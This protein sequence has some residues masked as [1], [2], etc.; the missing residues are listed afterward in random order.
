MTALAALLLALAQT[1]EIVLPPPTGPDPIGTSVRHLVD[2]ARKDERFAAGR[3]I[4]LQ[5]WYPAREST[6]KLAP[7]LMEDGLAHALEEQGYYEV[8]PARL[9]AWG[10]LVTHAHLDAPPT[11]EAHPLVTFCVGL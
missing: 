2:A 1:P 5:L 6:A 3:P 8:E 4:T 9:A 10:K 7:Y 11:P